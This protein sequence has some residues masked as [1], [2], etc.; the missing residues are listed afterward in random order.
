MKKIKALLGGDHNARN[1][2]IEKIRNLPDFSPNP[3]DLRVV[4]V[5]RERA[6][7]N[8]GELNMW[9]IWPATDSSHDFEIAHRYVESHY[10]VEDRYYLDVNALGRCE[11]TSKEGNLLNEQTIENILQN[12]EL[13]TMTQV[14][15]VPGN[16]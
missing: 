16:R 7:E 2:V 3:V 13:P 11:I 12:L 5:E 6:D 14:P 9:A 8:T 1:Q 4:F 10:F 15:N